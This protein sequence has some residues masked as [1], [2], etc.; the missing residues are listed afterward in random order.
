MI[1]QPLDK[2]LAVW[3]TI[4]GAPRIVAWVPVEKDTADPNKYTVDAI[5]SRFQKYPQMQLIYQG[6][7]LL[8]VTENVEHPVSATRLASLATTHT[9]RKMWAVYSSAGPNW[10]FMEWCQ[11]APT[12]GKPCLQR[13]AV[14]NGSIEQISIASAYQQT[15]MNLP[16]ATPKHQGLTFRK[17]FET[18]LDN[19]LA[20]IA[21]ITGW[22]EWIA[23]RIPCGQN[24]TCPCA[25]YPQGCFMDQYDGERNRDMEP[26]V[27]AMGDYYYRLLKACIAL[28]RS[29]AL[30]DAS[31]AADLCCKA[32]AP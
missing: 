21:T 23:Q 30:C 8:L 20:P 25:T 1:L 28:F 24:P 6:K 22:N 3:S 11:N 27:N 10:S 32:Y 31:H 18:L 9:V 12:S 26:A 5:I 13:S 15:Y 2:L 7:P 4:P 17:Q 14:L 16:S 29:G 19:P